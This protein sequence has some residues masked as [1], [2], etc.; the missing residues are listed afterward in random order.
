M[1]VFVVMADFVPFVLFDALEPSLIFGNFL[2][3]QLSHQF[4]RHLCHNFLILIQ[5]LPTQSLVLNY[6]HCLNSCSLPI[7]LSSD[8]L[9]LS[10]SLFDFAK[11][12]KLLFI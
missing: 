3:P 9:S 11:I 12:Y 8:Q 10:L 1:S 2:P 5:L 4:P 6:T 7:H